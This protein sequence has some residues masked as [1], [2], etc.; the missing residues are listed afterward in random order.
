MTT[1][2]ESTAAYL[3]SS[4]SS[5]LTRYPLAWLA[6][7]IALT[8]ATLLLGLTDHLWLLAS[9]GGS[10]VILFGM[11]DSE[12]AQPRSLIGG[13]VIASL[14]GLIFLRLGFLLYGGNP[15][16]WMIA[17]VATA[18]VLMMATRTIHSPAGANP[19][20]IFHEQAGW[21][22]L[23]SP[24]LLGLVMLLVVALAA[25]NTALSARYP[26]RWL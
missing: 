8:G 19:I 9:L 1:Q 14:A 23:V 21:S 15:D 11:P 17:A 26:Q 12:M 5:G 4:R 24:L 10:C 13:H 22:F 3:A 20:V 16:A 18:L 25:N 6:V 7:V 2:P